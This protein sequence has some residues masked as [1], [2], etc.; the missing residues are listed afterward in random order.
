MKI[1]LFSLTLIIITILPVNSQTLPP[2]NFTIYDSTENQGYYFLVSFTLIPPYT[3]APTQMILDNKGHLVYY[4][5]FGIGGPLGTSTDYKMQ[6]NG[7]V[8]FYV[9]TM[10]YIMDSTFIVKDSLTAANG[11]SADPHEM[12][13]LSNGHYLL[14][15]SESRTLDLSS[16]YWFGQNHNQPG[17]TNA[18]VKGAV[19]QEFDQNKNLV[20]EWKSHDKFQFSDV[21]SIWLNSPENV[22]WTHSNALHMDNDGNVLLSSRHF[23]EITKINKS[24]GAIMWRWGGKRNQFTF[25]NDTIGFTGQHHIRRISN[26]NV[27]LFDNG[28]YTDPPVARGLEYSLNESSKV[29]TL[30]WQY[31]Y[32]PGMYSSAMGDVQ[33]LTNNNTLVNYGFVDSGRPTFVVVKPNGFNWK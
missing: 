8:S 1:L 6:V 26:G 23:N 24:T 31:I 10:F 3:Y 18:T 11:F 21:D 2:Y 25:A 33:R 29:A 15:A 19:I 13:I 9:G 7:T 16:Y 12:I 4:R 14:L 27:T 5:G 32:D 22:D 17:S 30:I 28:Q 20:W